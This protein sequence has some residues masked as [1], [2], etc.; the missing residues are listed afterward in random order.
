MR[1]RRGFTLVELLV[2]I[3]IIA[4]LAAI[5]FPLFQRAR[6]QARKTACQSNLLQIGKAI[7][8]YLADNDDI[9]PTNRWWPGYHGNTGT[10]VSILVPLSCPDRIEA[11]EFGPNYVE[12]LSPYV[13]KLEDIRS[14]EAVWRC[15]SAMDNMFGTQ[16]YPQPPR[17]AYK[18]LPSVT[19]VMNWYVAEQAESAVFETGNTLLMR[20]ADRRLHAMLRPYPFTPPTPTS[21]EG[22]GAP[23]NCFAPTDNVL[24]GGGSIAIPSAYGGPALA[25]N[26]H[27]AGSNVLMVDT[28]V[29]YYLS[30]DLA[31]SPTL[32]PNGRYHVSGI[33][34]TIKG[35]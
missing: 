23:I 19:Y 29:K 8:L 1:S 5:L 25:P 11:E 26:R 12:A 9:Y 3:A 2:V 32:A 16:Y 4:I 27:F 17:G 21:P 22:S 30:A 6:E 20:E 28:H 31:V 18:A 7:K 34:V 24:G 14:S 35:T 10:F 15:P 33:Y 13:E